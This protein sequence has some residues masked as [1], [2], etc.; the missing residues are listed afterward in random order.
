MFILAPHLIFVLSILGVSMANGTAFIAV[1]GIPPYLLGLYLAYRN[2]VSIGQKTEAVLAFVAVGIAMLY[3][4]L[5]GIHYLFSLQYWL[6]IILVL[7]AF[8][9]MERRDYAFC[10]LISAALFAHVGRTYDDIPFLFLTLA[11]VFL[12]PYALFYFLACY[13]GFQKAEQFKAPTGIRFSAAQFRYMTGISL[14]LIFATVLLF[15][16]MPRPGRGTMLG[17]FIDDGSK[18]TG[19]SDTV[20]LG[21][22]SRVVEQKNIVMT[23]ETDEPAMWRS[24]VLDYYANGVWHAAAKYQNRKNPGE[25]PVD[26]GNRIVKRRYEIFDIRLS[27]FELFS[28]GTVLSFRKLGGVEWPVWI[29]DLYSTVT[30]NQF[31]RVV[32]LHGEYEI[33]SREGEYIGSGE[34]EARQWPVPE[35]PGR[36][37]DER[38][39]FLQLPGD[40]SLEVKNLAQTITRGLGTPEEKADAIQ[41]YLANAC[42]YSTKDLDSGGMS[43]LDYFLFKSKKGHCEYFASAMTILLRCSDVRARVVQGFVPGALVDGKYIVR[44]SDA[45]LWTEVFC[46]GRGW[47]TYDPTPG[48]R[49]AAGLGSQVGLFDKMK[50]RWQSYVLRYDGTRQAGFIDYLKSLIVTAAKAIKQRLYLLWYLLACAVALFLAVLLVRFRSW[51]RFFALDYV[52][53]GARRP[54]I[55]RVRSYFGQYLKEIARKG[56]KRGP[57]TTPNDLIVALERDGVSVIDEARLL[58]KVFYDTRFGG[59]ELP[60]TTEKKIELAVR[61]IRVWAK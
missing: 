40:L 25:A 32:D 54:V 60:C 24:G 29:N 52:R 10:F 43:P 34:L 58:T 50:L 56:Y 42:T 28:S 1:M 11:Y 6:V 4:R 7:R 49:A 2:N 44:L 46:P 18:V 21:T 22:F 14:F 19:L 13:G 35:M 33:E 3:A 41:R 15:V 59:A 37:I 39:L 16:F 48:R 61:K 57:A 31:R 51:F 23:V 53:G 20:S 38:A 26:L 12:L 5:Q 45:H 30:I 27:S 8:R 17:G 47:K 36:Q 9:K 55:N